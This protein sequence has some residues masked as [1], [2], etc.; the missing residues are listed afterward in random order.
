M[1][2]VIC[3][4]IRNNCSDGNSNETDSIGMF[5]FGLF[6]RDSSNTALSHMWLIIDILLA[7]M[8]IGI[9]N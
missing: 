1:R 4:V 2:A 9:Q 7:T 8:N 5:V 3:C 6:Q